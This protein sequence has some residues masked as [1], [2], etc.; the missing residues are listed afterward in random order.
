MD[1]KDFEQA[2]A[3]LL[4]LMELYQQKDGSVVI[5]KEIANLI[6]EQLRKTSNLNLD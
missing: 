1:L 4:R 3:A 2:R 5:P 6:K